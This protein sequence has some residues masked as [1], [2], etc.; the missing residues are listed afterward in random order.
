VH[1]TTRAGDA[2]TL[3]ARLVVGADGRG[4]RTAELAGLRTRTS[5]NGRFGYWGYFEG[6]PLGTGASVH[7]WFLEPDVAIATPTDGDLMLYVAFP[8]VSRTDEFK[9]DLEGALRRFIEAV[10]DAPPI[11]ESRRVGPM[12]GK[13]DLTN[14]W[15]R[16]TAPGLALVGDAAIAADPVGAIGCGWALQSAGWLTDSVAPA[17]V[18]G[19]DLRA[20][21]R[22][23]RRAHRKGLLGHSLVVAA[24]ARETQLGPPVRLMFSAAVHDPRLAAHVEA[25]AGRHIG[26]AAFL[27]P[28]HLLRAAA[29]NVRHRSARRAVK[30]PS[31]MAPVR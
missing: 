22:R 19:A 24:G 8:D 11:G 23:Y 4:S 9:A 30:R 31:R 17:L 7:I 14:E 6:P 3:R 16:A 10:P 26:P 27:G 29:V 5:R 12:V 1:I 25:F 21:L 2:T 13:L 20:P 28:R 18:A 15:R